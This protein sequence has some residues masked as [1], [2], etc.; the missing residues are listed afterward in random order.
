MVAYPVEIWPYTLR[1]RGLSVAWLSAIGALIF[2]TFV[3]PIALSAIGWKYYFVFVAI[4]ICYALTSYFFYPETKGYSLENMALL[5]EGDSA[6]I[7]RGKNDWEQPESSEEGA[8]KSAE[9]VELERV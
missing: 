8:E 6:A 9:T 3:N 5:F 7:A 4:L 1:S 2:N